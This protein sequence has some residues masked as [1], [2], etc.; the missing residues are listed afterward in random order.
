MYINVPQLLSASAVELLLSSGE[1]VGDPSDYNLG[2]SG[3][4]AF[5]SCT[6]GRHDE[7]SGSI[8]V[9]TVGQVR[10]KDDRLT[11]ANQVAIVADDFGVGGANIANSITIVW[12]TE[13]DCTLNERRLVC[14]KHRSGIVDELS[15]LT[16]DR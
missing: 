1:A 7:C 5:S 16:R 13:D 14:G 11:G 4:S 6:C 15:A 12:V 2:G 8:R 3:S 10:S 9:A